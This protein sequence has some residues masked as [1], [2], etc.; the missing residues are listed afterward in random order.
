MNS[1]GCTTLNSTREAQDESKMESVCVRRE[2]CENEGGEN[3]DDDE[4]KGERE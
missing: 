1:K 2:G 4:K 3:D